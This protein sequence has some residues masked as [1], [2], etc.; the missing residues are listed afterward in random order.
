M[1]VYNMDGKSR[2]MFHS[3]EDLLFLHK[4]DMHSLSIIR[5]DRNIKT[6][7]ERKKLNIYMFYVTKSN[8]H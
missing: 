7:G 6:W 8:E 5:K 4:L 2:S 1:R 3:S